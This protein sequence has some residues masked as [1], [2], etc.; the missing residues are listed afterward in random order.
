MSSLKISYSRTSSPELFD[1]ELRR[2]RLRRFDSSSAFLSHI[3]QASFVDRLQFI[4]RDFSHILVI[5]NFQTELLGEAQITHLPFLESDDL[6]GQL[7]RADCQEKFDLIISN[8]NLHQLND[9]PGVLWQIRHLL[10]PDGLFLGSLLGGETLRELRDAFMQAEM[11]ICGGVSPRVA[12]MI[13]LY[14]ASQLLLRADLKLPVADRD[15][16]KANYS[17][18][19]DL[20]QDLR[21]MGETNVMHSRL[22]RPSSRGLFRRLEELYAD[23]Y[24][25]MDGKLEATFEIIYLTGWAHHESQQQPLLP[26]SGQIHLS[27]ILS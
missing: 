24:C 14:T 7:G 4:K 16:I 27:K 8:L 20:M 13:D 21:W 23:K 6:G 22:R 2:Q 17:S 1:Y 19:K 26:G 12:P 9:L 5:G 18:V 15:V 25:H 10:Q 11:A 3:S